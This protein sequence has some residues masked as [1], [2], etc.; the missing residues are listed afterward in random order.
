MSPS[1][2][3]GAP[4][5]R[6]KTFVATGA[7]ILST[8]TSQIAG[9]NKWRIKIQIVNRGPQAI[10]MAE[11]AIKCARGEG[12]FL[13]SNQ[14]PFIYESPGELH[15]LSLPTDTIIVAPPAGALLTWT[16]NPI[17][18]LVWS[19]DPVVSQVSIAE[20]IEA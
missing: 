14:Q 11:T 13:E 9:T 4:R 15:C 1:W 20:E 19:P 7:D 12:V 18:F 6:R 16:S 17:D 5:Q 2:L 10:V 8:T 3:A